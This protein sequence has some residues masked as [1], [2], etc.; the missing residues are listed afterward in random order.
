VEEVKLSLFEVVQAD[1]YSF[2][3][4]PSR[5]VTADEV[6]ATQRGTDSATTRKQQKLA[7]AF[8]RKHGI[9]VRLAVHRM[10]D[11]GII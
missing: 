1:Y 6:A 8:A 4:Y 5:A 10:R 7:R 9:S 11:N 3:K 2:R